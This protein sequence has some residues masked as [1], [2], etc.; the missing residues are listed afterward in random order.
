MAYTINKTDGTIV[1]TI[2]DGTIN[3]STSLTLFGKSYSGFGE[4]LNENLVKLL[5]NQASTSTPT[6]PLT[7]ELWFDTNTAQLKVYDGSAF[8]PTGGAKSQSAQPSSASAGDFFHDT[9]DDQIYFYTGSAWQLLGPV[10]NST[11]TLSGWYIETLAS[12]GGDKL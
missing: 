1:A 5:E 9:D 11:Q 8:K 3:N 6:A 10:F 2:T 4:A 12:G 7:G